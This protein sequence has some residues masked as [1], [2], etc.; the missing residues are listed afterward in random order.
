MH[1]VKRKTY[2]ADFKLMIITEV[3]KG[4][5]KTALAVKYNLPGPGTIVLWMN[6]YEELGYNGLIPKVKGRPKS[7]MSPK[8]EAKTNVVID[9]TPLTNS[10][11]EEYEKLKKNY[12]ILKKEKEQSDMEIDLLKKLNALVQQRKQQQRKKK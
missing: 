7:N 12:E 3:Y 4:A 11:R 2:T 1:P 6:K 8:E 5:S 9:S 10:E